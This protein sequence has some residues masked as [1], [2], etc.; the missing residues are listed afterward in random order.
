MKLTIHTE[1]GSYESRPIDLTAEQAAQVQDLI[2]K[3]AA[4]G[5]YFKLDTPNGYVVLGSEL[6][7]T[8]AFV[9]EA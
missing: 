7:K 8:A 5:E 3:S 1:R 4:N 2:E 9:V 6:L